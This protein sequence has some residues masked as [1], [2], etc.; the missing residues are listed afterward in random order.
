[1]KAPYTPALLALALSTAIPLQAS[2]R[3]EEIIIV[4]SRVEMPLRLL[5][6]SVSTTDEQDIRARG[7]SNLADVL[8][9]EPAI[10]VSNSGGPGKSTSLRIRGENGFRTKVLMDGIDI[11]DTSSP[12]AAPIFEHIA[13]AGVERVEVLRGPQGLM[14][15]ADAGGIVTI[16]TRRPAPGFSGSLGGEFGRY[17]T[18]QVAGHLAGGS[19]ALDFSLAGTRFET[20]GFN[21]RS[22]DT[23]LRDTDGYDNTTVHASAGWNISETLRAELVGHSVQ[24]E[25]E[26]DACNTADTFAPT[27]DCSDD[28]QRRAW[29]AVLAHQGNTFSNRLAYS[30][31]ASER[32]FYAEGEFTFG[33]DGELE[34]LEYIGSWNPADS[35]K[36]VYGLDLIN[37]AIDDGSFD[38]DRDQ[39]GVYLEYQ[40]RLADQLYLTAGIRH[41]DNDDFGTHTT[42]RLSAAYLVPMDA[43]ELKL[44]GSYGTGFRAPSLYEISYNGGPFAYPPAAGVNLDAEESE[45]YDLGIGW[46]ASAGWFVEAVYFDQRV[47]N[48]IFFDLVAFSGYLQG[49][50]D[51]SSSGVELLAEVPVGDELALTGNYTYNDTEDA[52][53][54]QRLRVPEQLANLGL[55]YRPLAGRLALHLYL[56]LSR[57]A[58]DGPG[59]ELNDYEVLNLS[60]SYRVLDSLELYGRVENLADQDYVEVPGF[61]TAGAAAYAGLR[62][63]F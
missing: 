21:T 25:N 23:T 2:E 43:G 44:K 30:R 33:A 3:L 9:F 15:G 7:V 61:N 37:E 34:K 49:D 12:Q 51:S 19:E 40:G 27:D 10:S 28:Y 6:T 42:Y 56:R 18:R 60:A 35:L 4:S 17:D 8:R 62:Y 41:D 22:S 63:T 16:T 26:F 58:T 55:S 32:E 53:G 48:E 39:D 46:F 52:D 20:D 31:N 47:E 54:Q 57:N 29:R 50:G 24:G 45:G 38:T 59:A 5:G 13:S 14:Y 36:L 1:M 11:T